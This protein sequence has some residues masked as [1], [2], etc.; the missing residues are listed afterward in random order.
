MVTSFRRWSWLLLAALPVLVHADED[1][2]ALLARVRAQHSAATVVSHYEIRIVRADWQRDI[3]VDVIEDQAGGRYQGEITAPRRL[4]GTLYL[5]RDGR[6]WMVI[7]KLHRKVGISAAMLSEAWMGSDLSNQ[8]ILEGDAL[9]DDYQHR[10]VAR[11]GDVV[12]IESTPRADRPVLWKRLVQRVRTDAVPLSV[13]YYD[14]DDQCVRRI[15]F[16]EVGIV[17]ARHL[18]MRWRITPLP[19][20][21]EY[22]ELRVTGIAFDPPL[23]ADAFSALERATAGSNVAP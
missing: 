22:T 21:G 20:R 6:L 12:T 4:A 19:E 10:V 1:A 18:P 15:E 2:A 5:K 9:I 14:Q 7:P 23:A 8:D 3:G 17:G 13:A 16:S 11:D